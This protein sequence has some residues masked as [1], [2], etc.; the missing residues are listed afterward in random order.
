M[1]GHL[2][3]SAV[4]GVD[5]C[6]LQGREVHEMTPS[7]TP[8]G[9]LEGGSLLAQAEELFGHC[10]P[11]NT[12]GSVTP[13]H[14]CGYALLKLLRASR[15]G[16]LEAVARRIVGDGSIIICC[17]HDISKAHVPMYLMRELLDA[18]PPPYTPP[19]DETCGTCGGKGEVLRGL[20]YEDKRPVLCP[21]CTLKESQP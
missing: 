13:L 1:E 15:E 16:R 17:N 7:P 6:P 3:H 10:G 8:I 18:L 2:R 9:E 5:L 14:R 19:S 4:T 11:H 12:L 20:P 21:D